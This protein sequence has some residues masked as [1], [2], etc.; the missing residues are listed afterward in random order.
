MGGQ[1]RLIS[2][3]PSFCAAAAR[4]DVSLDS[5]SQELH[6]LPASYQIEEG[7]KLPGVKV[8]MKTGSRIGAVK[9]LLEEEKCSVQGVKRCGME[10]EEIYRSA[11][12]ISQDAGYYSLFI[13]RDEK[14]EK[15]GR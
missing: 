10:G 15:E 13:V 3:V 5:G 12:E 2:G 1:G 6:I 14:E 7:L 9:A 4:L 11:G 8:L